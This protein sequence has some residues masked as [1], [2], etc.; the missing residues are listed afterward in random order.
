MF[1]YIT[2]FIH[3][4]ALSAVNM[5]RL[6]LVQFTIDVIMFASLYVCLCLLQTAST[7]TIVCKLIQSKFDKN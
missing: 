1:L 2:V 3:A 5:Q 7:T 4:T 6:R